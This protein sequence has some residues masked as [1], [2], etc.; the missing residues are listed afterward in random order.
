M[1]LVLPSVIFALFHIGAGGNPLGAFLSVLFGL[2]LGLM[3]GMIYLR[4]GSFIPSM[5]YHLLINFTGN[6]QA[7]GV[8]GT[9]AAGTYSVVIT[10]LI[11]I[12]FIVLSFFFVRPAVRPGIMNIWKDKLKE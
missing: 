11:C 1:I 2:G 4:S 7:T 5:I 12:V 10:I 9:G 6:L 3:N 8:T